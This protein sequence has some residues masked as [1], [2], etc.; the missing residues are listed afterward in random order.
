MTDVVPSPELI[1]Q[2]IREANH[3][4]P[5]F[6]QVAVMA[7]KWGYQ[8]CN[9]EYEFAAMDIVSPTWLVEDDDDT[10]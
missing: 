3:N 4:E 9:A 5:M 8:Q 10:N 6:A 2:W 1:Q 7:A